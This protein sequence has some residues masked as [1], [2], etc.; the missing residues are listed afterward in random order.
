MGL[1]AARRDPEL[2]L[3]LDKAD[4]STADGMPVAWALRSMG[5]PDQE[6]IPGAKVTTT[7]LETGIERGWR[8]YFYGSIVETLDK[9]RG[10]IEQQYDGTVI[11]GTHS[12]LFRD[13]EAAEED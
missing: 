2:R 11:P 9:L 8:H 6:R 3:A 10:A 7:A 5:N 4:I 13:L 1:L 12:P